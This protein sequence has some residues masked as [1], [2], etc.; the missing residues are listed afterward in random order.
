MPFITIASELPMIRTA[1]FGASGYSGRELVRILL[2]HP[3]AVVERIFAGK[4]AGRDLAAV[5]PEFRGRTG[6]GL[7]P[8]EPGKLEGLD[9]AFLALP[10]GGS[11]AAAPSILSAGLK[12]VDLSGDFRFAD[13]SIYEKWYGRSHTAAALLPDFVYGLPELFGPAIRAARAVANPGCY[14]TSAILGLAPLLT[15]PDFE[16]GEAIVNSISGVS[17]AGRRNDQ[18]YSFCELW[19]SVKAY[20]I[21]GH[22]HAPEMV[23]QLEKFSGRRL[24]VVFVPH[25]VPIERGIYTTIYVR[26]GR[27]AGL[28][29]IRKHY[30]AFYAPA[31]FVRLTD[32]PP[33][34]KNIV[35]TNYCD[36]GLSLD[37]DN[38]WL[39]VNSAIDNLVKGAAGQ[40]VQNMNLLF[41]LN[42]K[43]GLS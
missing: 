32:G 15:F 38:G 22:Q 31:P 13:A 35:G 10:H 37:R 29:E 14:P 40:A 33:E 18:A 26:P 5:Y 25:L 41:G 11:M 20:K 19:G 27:D 28:D 39:V 9:L 34:L 8:F 6:L 3:G 17:G 30:A 43:E 23:V 24:K 36:I 16:A 4:S 1:V 42:E 2:R 12:V 7:E 21:G